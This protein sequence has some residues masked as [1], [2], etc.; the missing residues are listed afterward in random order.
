MRFDGPEFAHAWL[1]VRAAAGSDKKLPALFRTMLIEEYDSE[2][3]SGFVLYATDRYMLLKAWVPEVDG[4]PA[5]A[6]DEAPTRVVVASDADSRAASLLGY[7]L[8]L[9]GR[10]G[11]DYVHGSIPV[12][13]EFDQPI[14]AGSGGAAEHLEG[15]APVYVVLS[16]PDVEKVYLEVVPVEAPDWRYLI[17]SYVPEHTDHITF[18]AELAERLAKVRKHASGRLVLGFGGADRAVLV[19]FENSDPHISGVLMPVADQPGS[20]HTPHT[21][22]RSGVTESRTQRHTDDLTEIG[23]DL[24]L[25]VQAVELVVSTQFGSTSMLQRKMRVGFA[26]AGRLMEILESHSVVGPSEGA[27]ARDVL[28]RPDNLAVVVDA[29]RTAAI[30]DGQ[31][32]S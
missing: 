3:Y 17:A 1:A 21:A 19:E 30:S 22:Q 9:A 14:P 8:S 2:E 11:D 5:P 27:K 12:R 20:S 13:V 26:K 7:V 23:D 18:G 16:V 15:M 28:V 24:D 29:I 6:M 32:P 31:A 10:E 25:V 4:G